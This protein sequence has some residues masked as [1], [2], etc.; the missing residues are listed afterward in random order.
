MKV[1]VLGDLVVLVRAAS[2]AV[3]WEMRAAPRDSGSASTFNT[4]VL[5]GDGR[6]RGF[7]GFCMINQYGMR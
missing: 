2:E 1:R 6:I 4:S 3:G 5:L 7:F